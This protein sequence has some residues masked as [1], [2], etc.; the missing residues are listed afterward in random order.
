MAAKEIEITREDEIKAV[1]QSQR[2]RPLHTIATLALATG[3]RRGELC[4]L[5]WKDVDLD[6]GKIR[7]EQSLE[8]T[9][10]GLRFK[11][12]KTRHARRTIAIPVSTVVELRAYWSA[13]QEQRLA[14]GLGRSLPGDLVFAAWDGTPRKPNWL[15]NEWL[16]ATMAVGRRISLHALR[17]TH[18]SSLIAAGIDILTISRRLGH[19]NPSVTLGVYGH[20]YGNTDERAAEAIEAMFARV[21]AE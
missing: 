17:H 18:A 12:P 5:R 6:G 3:M 15:T 14:L 21:R 2:G 20:M 11:S 19:A 1:L 8:Q 9:K 7:V 13:Q 16:R 4:G 10:A